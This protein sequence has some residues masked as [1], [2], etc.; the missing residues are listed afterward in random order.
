MTRKIY[1]VASAIF[2]SAFLLVFFNHKKSMS[3]KGVE[4][5]RK[6]VIFDLGANV[7]DSA[8]LFADP[9]YKCDN[10]HELRGICTRF[11][12]TWIIY[13]F[14]ANPRYNEILDNVTKTV[15]KYGHTHY[16]YKQS[17]AWIRNEN[18]TFYIE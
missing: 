4:K 12:Q 3:V 16:L 18:L 15:Q 5:M 11:N 6:N 14:E 7:G 17:A 2:I 1:I 10:C 13:S 8:L 9:E